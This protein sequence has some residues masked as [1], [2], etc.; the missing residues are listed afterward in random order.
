MS[1][2]RTFRGVAYAIIDSFVSRNNDC[3]GY[4][5]LG[6]L[7]LE[8]IQAGKDSVTLSLYP[9]TKHVEESAGQKIEKFWS[10]R[11]LEHLSNQGVSLSRIKSARIDVKFN[12]CDRT[13][14]N[15]R[16][17]RYRFTYGDPFEA[18]LILCSD[19]GRELSVLSGGWCG[20]HDPA[21][22]SQSTRV[23]A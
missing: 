3:D 21:R 16:A 13:S 22:E 1:G 9:E 5:A 6:K 12:A 20:P 10:Q 18:E 7:Y 23:D 2:S 8:A 15:N 11:L 4:W 17:Q 19:C 14:Y